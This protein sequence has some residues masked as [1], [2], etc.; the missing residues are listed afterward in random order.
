MFDNGNKRVWTTLVQKTLSRRERRDVAVKDLPVS[1]STFLEINIGMIAIND[2]KITLVETKHETACQFNYSIKEIY[3]ALGCQSYDDFFDKLKQRGIHINH[4]I[5]AN[6]QDVNDYV[7]LMADDISSEF[8]FDLDEKTK[9]LIEILGAAIYYDIVFAHPESGKVGLK[10]SCGNLITPAIFDAVSTCTDMFFCRTLVAVRLDG[11]RYFTPRDGSGELITDAYDHTTHTCAYGWVE[12][13]GM[14]GLID[15]RSG[16]VLIPCEMDWLTNERT[17]KAQFIYGKNGKIG[18]ADAN[19]INGKF[20]F[21]TAPIYEAIDITRN[22]FLMNGNWWFLNKNGEYQHLKPGKYEE[23]TYWFEPDNYLEIDKWDMPY[24][25]LTK[26]DCRYNRKYT[27]FTFSESL[28]VDEKI[29]DALCSAFALVD[30][31]LSPVVL[32]FNLPENKT[33]VFAG[34]K[35]YRKDDKTVIEPI[36]E[37]NDQ[38]QLFNELTYPN[39][40]CFN[41]LI[42][43]IDGK[44]GMQFYREFSDSEIND[45]EKLIADYFS[46]HLG[47]SLDEIDLTLTDE[48]NHHTYNEVC[49]LND[50]SYKSL[51]DVGIFVFVENDDCQKGRPHFHIIGNNCDIQ[52]EINDFNE[53]KAVYES[54]EAHLTEDLRKAL[55]DWLPLPSIEIG[56]TNAELL[57]FVWNI[58]NQ[59]NKIQ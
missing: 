36:W 53:V 11:K 59:D 23:M 43:D 40:K 41:C 57:R 27:P 10:D 38:E 58:N 3:D 30:A 20:N 44:F 56:F 32:R 2:I 21:Y 52:I 24:E 39:I 18:F 49:R 19:P 17:I 31:G 45:I 7:D 4:D 26:F 35:F 54:H 34:L 28:K 5:K 22:I 50:K 55:A 1:T 25:K 12:R 33:S 37:S 51:Q 15:S 42:K 13:M 6:T 14:K 9:G 29:T 8:K 46:N 16:N 48:A 47:V